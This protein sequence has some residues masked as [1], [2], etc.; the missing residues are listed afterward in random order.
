MT[1]RPEVLA[2]AG[3]RERME[4]AVRYGADAVYL[5]GK[6]FGMRASSANFDLEELRSAVAFA[7]EHGV[8]VYLT[9][10]TN[11]LNREVEEIEP[12]LVEAAGCGVDAFIVA[13]IGVLMMARRVAP[14]VDVHISTQ[15]GVT[16]YVTATELHRLGA[17]RVVLARELSLE[18]VKTIRAKTPEDLE[19]ECF[20]HGA[21]C[22][23]FSGRCLLSNYF[24]G[25]DANRGECAQP[26]RWKYYLMEEKRPGQFYP[27][28]EDD[29][30]SYILNAKD[31]SMIE[32]VKE[33]ADAGISSIKIEGRAK[34]AY[35]VSVTT[36]AYRQAVDGYLADPEH[37]VTPAWLVE[38]VE[39]V[40]HRAYSTGFYY[41]KPHEGQ[42]LENGGYIRGWDVVAMVKEAKEGMLFL[43]QRNK[44]SVG[45][46]LEILEP[47]RQPVSIPVTALYDGD[48]QAIESASHA[49]MDCR[50]PFDG[51]VLP[52]SIVR[53]QKG[54]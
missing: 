14:S 42:C 4:A 37:F 7:H 34:S 30:G 53:K 54:E 20:V 41:G 47:G 21:M 5:G 24:T 36:N 49:T 16:N 45:D 26:C 15:A 52:G 31:L 35:Y 51:S 8:R 12:F 38:E 17:K 29:T 50:I 32:H 33:L 23:S 1:R 46:T 18:E 2:P 3:D 25:R 39:K 48:G 22:M 40:S 6:Q 13:D 27:V 28:T 43:S 44:F 19:I 11:P 10:N 9:C